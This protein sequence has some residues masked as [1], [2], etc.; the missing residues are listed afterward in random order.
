MG[1]LSQNFDSTE[2]AC[3]CG[4]GYS[5]PSY[6]LIDNLQELRDHWGYPITVRSGCRCYNH[7]NSDSVLGS[8][9]SYH[10]NGMGADI[11]L[12]DILVVGQARNWEI[13]QVMQEFHILCR[14]VFDG[15]GIIF[16]PVKKFV[17][18]DVRGYRYLP[19]PVTS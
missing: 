16:Y 1:D 17:H 10:L 4:C 11:T 3:H 2:F 18:V 7:N 8:R 9:N 5:T 13:G 6:R 12:Q 15:N 19:V 14:D